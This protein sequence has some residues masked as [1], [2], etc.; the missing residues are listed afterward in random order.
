[1]VITD[2]Q[3][4]AFDF[5]KNRVVPFAVKSLEFSFGNGKK[6]DMTG[7]RGG[8][9]PLRKIAG[10]SG[11]AAIVWLLFYITGKGGWIDKEKLYWLS[12]YDKIDCMN[13]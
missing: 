10:R 5:R 9:G 3:A 4:E 1:M 2:I 7:S 8:Y 6:V 13:K 12:F 11:R